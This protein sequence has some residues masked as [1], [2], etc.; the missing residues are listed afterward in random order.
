MMR[1]AA[2]PRLVPTLLVLTLLVPTAIAAAPAASARDGASVIVEDYGVYETR[3]DKRVPH[4][5][6]AT[7]EMNIISH[8]RFLRKAKTISAQLGRSFGWRY[9][10]KGV[11]DNAQVTFRTL[12]PPI[13]N[14]DTGRT[15]TSS[16]R[17]ITVKKPF[18][19]RYTG[20]TFDYSWELAEGRW[21][22]QVLYGGKVIGERA[23]NIVIP[24]N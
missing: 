7:G 4:P 16:W 5:N 19:L 6:S 18:N 10:L 14:P 2:A 8:L 24:L 3:A 23:F 17:T 21:A 11:P 9:R 15:K 22:F 13:T 12:H 20:Y 1:Y